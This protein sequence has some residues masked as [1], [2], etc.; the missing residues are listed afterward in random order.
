M[1]KLIDVMMLAPT[2]PF[3]DVT[4]G[5][6]IEIMAL[7]FATGLLLVLGVATKYKIFLILAVGGLIEFIIIWAS[8]PALVITIVGLIIWCLWYATIGSRME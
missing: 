8:Y 4:E 7:M 6:A 3:A 2:V 1:Y 5:Q